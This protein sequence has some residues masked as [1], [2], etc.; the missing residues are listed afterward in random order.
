MLKYYHT[1]VLIKKISFDAKKKLNNFSKEK[2]NF[3]YH[4][5][6]ILFSYLHYLKISKNRI[7]AAF[8]AWIK[9]LTNLAK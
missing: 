6:F 9:W 3:I 7:S 4:S 8:L 5:I 2:I 1:I